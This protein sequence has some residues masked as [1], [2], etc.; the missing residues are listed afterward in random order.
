VL[1]TFGGLLRSMPRSGEWMNAVKQAFGYALVAAALYFVG[2]SRLV[3]DVWFAVLVGASML[4]A[5]VFVGAFDALDAASAAS[6]RLRK[7]L[8]LLLLAGA[9]GV[10]MGPLARVTGRFVDSAPSGAADRLPAIDWLSSEA[11]ALAV[12]RAQDRP[13]LLDFWAEWCAECVRMSKTTFVDP[14]VVAEAARFAS[15]KIDFDAL[16]AQERARLSDEYGVVGL[17]FVV[18]IDTS[19]RRRSRAA[20]VG[21]DEMLDLLRATD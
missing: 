6:E 20:Y 2:K 4:T 11:D 9:V 5:S 13:V 18:I 7:A 1:G 8:G 16:T 10:L 17:P 14:R 21:P 15:A 19:G 3:P 12:A